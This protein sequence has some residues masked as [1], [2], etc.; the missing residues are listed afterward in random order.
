MILGPQT[1]YVNLR[2]PGDYPPIKRGP[3]RNAPTQ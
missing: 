2:I 1:H 3:E